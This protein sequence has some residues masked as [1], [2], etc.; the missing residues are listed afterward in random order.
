MKVMLK[1]IVA[2][3]F[4]EPL[5]RKINAAFGR[6]MSATSTFDAAEWN[7]YDIQTLEV[8]KRVLRKNSNCVDV[9]CHKGSILK[10]MLRLAP[11]GAHFAFEPLPEMYQRLLESFGSIHG[12]HIYDFALSDTTGETTFQYVIDNPAF[13]GFR[14]RRY[15]RPDE[16]VQEITVKAELLDNLIPRDIPIQFIKVDVEGAELQVFRGATETIKNSRPVIVFEHGLGAADYYGTSPEKIY[17]LLAL[18][19][20]LRMFLISD[21]LE[22]NGRDALSREAFC[23]HFYQGKNYYFLAAI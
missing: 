19:C 8:M 5:A 18:Q 2:G 21:W 22:S 12:L 17:D 3:T 15:D 11:K 9:G 13:S 20:S 23:E 4:Q 14:K 7:A 16:Q 10:E 6:E 1:K